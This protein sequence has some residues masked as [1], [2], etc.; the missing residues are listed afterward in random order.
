[1]R[2]LTVIGLFVFWAAELGAKAVTSVS[3]T[4][5]DPTGAAVPNAAVTLI[6]DD[7]SAQRA[8]TTDPEG[9]YSFQQMQPGRYHLTAKAPGFNDVIVNDVL[10]N[11]VEYETKPLPWRNL[12]ITIKADRLAAWIALP[13]DMKDRYAQAMI[14]TYRA[15]LHYAGNVKLSFVDEHQSVVTQYVWTP[16][17]PANAPPIRH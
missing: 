14:D 3:G 16:P 4:V 7:T 6:N 1:M 15:G 11:G 12:A 9:R 10:Y 2:I 17:A 8:V 13:Q 5:T